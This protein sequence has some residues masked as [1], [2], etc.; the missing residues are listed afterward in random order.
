MRRI[1]TDET[2]V[3]PW[4]K[5]GALANDQVLTRKKSPGL[6]PRSYT[7]LRKESP[8]WEFRSTTTTL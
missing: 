5:P 6:P 7:D 4:R 3:A 1:M 2:R 8:M